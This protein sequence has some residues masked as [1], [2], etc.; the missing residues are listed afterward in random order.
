MARS[1]H[2][3]IDWYSPDP[4]A[5][6]PLDRFHVS[7]SLRRRV[8]AGTFHITHDTAFAEV[9]TACA[10]PR[11]YAEQTWINDQIVDAYT[12]LHGAGAAHSIEAWA[13]PHLAV[14]PQGHPSDASPTP[15]TDLQLVGGLYGVAIAGAFFGESMFSRQTDASKVCLVHLVE[16]LR[17][18]GF[19]LL[20][21][22][23][24]TPHLAQFGIEEIP[25]DEYLRRLGEALELDVTW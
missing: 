20:D 15:P 21:V 19:A 8:G 4:R 5:I 13:P 17:S 14:G 16:H 3:K 18:R 9:I 25:R 10:Q 1:R 2:G 7:R 23:F 11:P 24:A 6:M 12:Q 22:Q